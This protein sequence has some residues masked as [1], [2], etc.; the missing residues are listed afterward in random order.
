M[1]HGDL[2]AEIAPRIVV[3][4][5]GIVGVLPDP[6]DKKYL[7]AIG[8]KHWAEA[9]RFWQLNDFTLRKIWDLTAR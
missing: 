5:E 4:F 2:S 7:K 8:K 9:I 6:H 3:V 1:K